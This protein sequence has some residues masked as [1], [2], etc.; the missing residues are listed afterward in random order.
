MKENGEQ[1]VG[2]GKG[3]SVCHLIMSLIK[4]KQATVLRHAHTAGLH[5]PQ[6]HTIFLYVAHNSKRSLSALLGSAEGHSVSLSLLKLRFFFSIYIFPPSLFTPGPPSLPQSLPFILLLLT[7]GHSTL[8]L[9]NSNRNKPEPITCA[10]RRADLA[11]GGD[12][13]GG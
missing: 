5:S 2:G 11:N 8:V 4:S 9:I 10:A 7:S 3:W 1:Y 13:P 12:P 6:S